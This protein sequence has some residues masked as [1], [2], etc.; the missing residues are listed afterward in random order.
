MKVW[1]LQSPKKHHQIIMCDSS[2]VTGPLTCLSNSFSS[3][4]IYWAIMYFESGPSEL[5]E[6]GCAF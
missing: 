6:R 4:N 1:Q 5:K 2:K 3:L